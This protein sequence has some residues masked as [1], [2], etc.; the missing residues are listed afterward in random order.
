[1]IK[2][3][4][5]CMYVEVVSIRQDARR[6]LYVW[7]CTLYAIHDESQSCAKQ[8]VL[9]GSRN[10]FQTDR[11]VQGW[12]LER[13]GWTEYMYALCPHIVYLPWMLYIWILP[14]K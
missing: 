7:A 6:N 13:T 8:A 2:W 1:M 5:V 4:D 10:D 12:R 14:G 3:E 11:R 9:I